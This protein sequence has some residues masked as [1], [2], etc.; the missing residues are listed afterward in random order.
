MRC[1]VFSSKSYDRRFLEPAFN[2]LK[3][4]AVFFEPKLSL[5]TCRLADGFDAACVFVNDRLDREV[6][7]Q[8]SGFGIKV[9]VLRC[10]GFNQLDVEAAKSLNIRVMRVPAYSPHAVAEH[11]LGLILCLN[12]KLHKANHRVRENNFSL[13]GLLGFD[14]HS[15]TVGVV[16]TG[17]IGACVVR[18][19]KGF[20][21]EVLMY[22]PKPNSELANLGRYIS[23]DEL[24]RQ[25]RIITLHCPLSPETH[26]L[27]NASAISN[28]QPGVML[29]NTSRG[30][31]IDTKAAIKA[32]KSGKIGQL[33]LDVYEEESELFFEDLSERVVQDDVFSRLL[34]FPNVLITAHQAFFTEEALQ[35]IA[36]VTSANLTQF[37]SGDDLANAVC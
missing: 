3:H 33:A 7:E 4:E 5:E 36:D 10:A 26:H 21:C 14:L 9:I 18:L 34:T 28:M 2:K 35:G 16:G 37:E 22:D 12:R 15:K 1:A 25:S 27:I 31:L 8:L 30:G 29:I 13:E 17:T 32:L 19:L 24:F 6:L 20:G 23:L 11:A